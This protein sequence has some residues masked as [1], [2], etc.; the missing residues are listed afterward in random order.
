MYAGRL[1]LDTGEPWPIDDDEWMLE[2]VDDIFAGYREV[3][4]LVP[5]GNAKTTLMAAVGAASRDQAEILFGQAAG[6]VERTP[7]LDAR[8]YQPGRFKVFEGYRQIKSTI[9][10]GRGIKVYAADKATGDG[11]IPFPYA[12]IDEPHRH[13]DLGL[14]RT[15]KGKLRKRGA[16]IVAIST[17]GEPGTDFEETRDAIR[18]AATERE[19]VTE[20]HLRAAGPT[21]VMHEFKVPKAEQAKD[22]RLVRRANPLSV[23][24]EQDLREKLESPTLDYGED[25]LRL[26]CNIPARSSH[27]AISDADWDHA[28][29]DEEIPEGAAIDLGADFAWSHDTTAIVPLWMPSPELRLLGPPRVLT[30]P[31]DGTMLDPQEVKDAFDWFLT[32]YKV[33][34]VVADKTKAQDTL[35]WLQN[36]RGVDVVDWQQGLKNEIWEYERFMEALRGGASPDDRERRESWLKHT[37]DPELRRHVMN[38]IARK[39]PGDK[40]VFDRPSTSRNASKQDRR[41]I[42]ALKAAAMVH[43]S[44]VMDAAP[45]RSKVPVSL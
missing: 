5:E 10:G 40:R 26:T 13:K 43:C 14:Y 4:L 25:W 38:A 18:N 1:V 9:N 23:I 3:W 16:Q 44:A 39:V 35:L 22:L 32:Q 17:A 42:D 41:V 36:E 28:H 30:P 15:W 2:V 6:F 8:Q 20:C 24:T 7:G 37:G 31:R 34:R 12:L 33:R 29:T 19:H 21:T 11:V 45:K 27:A